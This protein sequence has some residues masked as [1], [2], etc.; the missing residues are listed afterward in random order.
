MNIKKK[1]IVGIAASFFAVATMFNM[2]M[3][4]DN[5]AG[6]VSLDAIAVMAE[7]GGEINPDCPNGCVEGNTGCI[8]YDYYVNL[9]EYDGW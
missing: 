7:A 6:D 5:G 4:K 2:G 1:V 9:A 3:L 8:C